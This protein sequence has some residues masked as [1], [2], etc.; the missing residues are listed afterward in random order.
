MKIAKSFGLFPTKEACIYV[1]IKLSVW[2]KKNSRILEISQ[3]SAGQEFFTV[4]KFLTLIVWTV[5]EY[6]FK[7]LFGFP[8]FMT[9]MVFLFLFL[10][11]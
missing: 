7:I 10:S 3:F 2:D 6:S 1:L 4:V 8:Q 9:F 11:D 5:K